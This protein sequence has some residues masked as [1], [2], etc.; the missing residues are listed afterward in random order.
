[1]NTNEKLLIVRERMKVNNV[2][3]L[4][5]T[6]GDPHQSEYLADHYKTREYISGFTGSNG[7]AVVTVDKALIWTDGRY[8]IQCQNE[9]K[10]SEFQMKKIG[11][12]NEITVSEFLLNEL[13]AGDIIEVNLDYF[14]RKDYLELEEKLS[15]KSIRIKNG[16]TIEDIWD[17]QPPISKEKIFILED[18]YSGESRVSKIQRIHSSLKEKKADS[19]F[20]SSLEDIAWILNIRGGDIPNNPVTTSFL[21]LMDEGGILFVHSSKVSDE[22]REEL[23][24]DGIHI[25]D[26]DRTYE[27]LFSI[28]NRKIFIDPK[29][30]SQ[31]VVS[32]LEENNQ[33]IYGDEI[34][35]KIKSIKNET[36]ISNLKYAYLQ[37]G[38][39]L[40]KFICHIKNSISKGKIGEYDASQ[41]LRSFRN[42]IEGYIDDSFETISAY[43]A[44]AAMMHYSASQESQDYIDN[45]GLY[46]VDSGGQYLHGTTDTTRT[47]AVGPLSQEEIHDY[48]LVLK[49]SI[50]LLNLVFLKGTRDSDLDIIARAPI[51]S[52]GKDYKC[53]TGH[54]VGYLLSV[55][56]APPRLSFRHSGNELLLGQMFT[57]EPGIYCEDQYGIRIENTVIVEK[58]MTTKDGEFFKLLNLTRVPVDLDAIDVDMLTSTERNFLNS[59]HKEVY[60]DLAPYMDENELQWLKGATREI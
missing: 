28:E 30:N 59:Y 19:T 58:A 49:S 1:M 32:I 10:N 55:H 27:E 39:A 42:K 44:N 7:T 4:L 51:W 47:I 15:E 8:F 33:I 16:S 25:I 31:R 3:A 36:E 43:G 26:Y 45:S 23:E 22:I 53:G 6:T 35:T 13:N 38:I 29:R 18:K 9:I 2:Q 21:F 60:H 41:M 52:E 54:G 56:E 57:V 12:E 11:I 5:V 40:T 34:S 37:D 17:Q 50:S 14:P 20:I 24:K 48:T 46:L